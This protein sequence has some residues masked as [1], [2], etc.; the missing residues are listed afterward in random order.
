[1]ILVTCDLPMV[2]WTV[3]A[4]AGVYAVEVRCHGYFGARL[5]EVL[6]P[7]PDLRA[8]VPVPRA[9]LSWGGLD[10]QILL[11]LTFV[12]HRDIEGQDDRHAN[13]DSPAF[14]GVERRI[15]LL[16]QRQVLGTEGCRVGVGLV[17]VVLAH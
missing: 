12:L 10:V 3:N 14:Q 11:E 17:D 4:T 13:T 1:L 16:V 5:P 7:V 9:S 15:G 8:G 2:K 6:G